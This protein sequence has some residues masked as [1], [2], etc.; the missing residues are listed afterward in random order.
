MTVH[1]TGGQTR[2]FIHLQDTVKC[3]QLALENPPERGDRER[4]D[5]PRH[6]AAEHIP[7]P[8]LDQEDRGQDRP[9]KT[10]QSGLHV[11]LHRMEV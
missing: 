3:I 7:E 11:R 1:G 5:E 10:G 9:E 2:A 8:G 4:G 6:E